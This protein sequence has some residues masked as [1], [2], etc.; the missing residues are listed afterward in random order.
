M[1]EFDLSDSPQLAVQ[2]DIFVFQ[3]CIGIRTGDFYKLTKD[4]V[5][6]DSIEYIANKT[7]NKTART[8]SVPLIPQAKTILERYRDENRTELLPFISTVHYNKTRVRHKKFM[9]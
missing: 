3:S 6:G 9:Q 5:V 1:F 7:L 2:R 8:V 4:N